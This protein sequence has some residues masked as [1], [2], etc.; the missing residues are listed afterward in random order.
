MRE[1]IEEVYSRWES[2]WLPATD[3]DVV[4]FALAYLLSEE[5]GSEVAFQIGQL[6][7]VDFGPDTFS[8]DIDVYEE[9]FSRDDRHNRERETIVG[10]EV[11]SCTSPSAN[12]SKE[13]MYK[14]I[15]QS[16]MLLN[17]PVDE[18]GG[19]LEYVYIAYPRPRN[20]LENQWLMCF[21]QVLRETPIGLVI[22]DRDG[23]DW[24]ID[25]GQ[26]PFYDETL[27]SI[28]S[29][30]LADTMDVR[31]PVFALS[32]MARRIDREHPDRMPDLRTA[33]QEALEHFNSKK[34]ND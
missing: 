31:S 17:Q 15:G 30:R 24:I 14:A 25:A 12:L 19:L 33:I 13:Q 7:K 4:S 34:A 6:E 11:K 9:R 1:L 23:L 2:G 27:T 26:N 32:N 28:V 21:E 10:Y 8:P 22:V 29:H 18:H 16:W 20:G 5:N 3:E